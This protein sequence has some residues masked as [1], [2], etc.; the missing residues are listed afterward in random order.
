MKRE[1]MFFLL[2]AAV[3]LGITA[4]A[5]QMEVNPNP[6][7]ITLNG[8]PVQIE[9]YNLNDSTYFKLRDIGAAL[10]FDVDFDNNTIMIT[11]N[12]QSAPPSTP[13]TSD[14]MTMPPLP[15]LAPEGEG[16]TPEKTM[17]EFKE[18]LQKKVEAG[19]MTQAEADEL[20][21]AFGG[22]FEDTPQEQ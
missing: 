6:F 16:A 9:G 5:A 1:A 14:G 8:Q 20:I 17:T 7:A 22:R 21:K 10:G 2:G 11:Q 4:F 19:E 12:R 13:S 15:S 18:R 3:T